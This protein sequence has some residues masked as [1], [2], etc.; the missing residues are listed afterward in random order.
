MNKALDKKIAIAVIVV[1]MI[2][3]QIHSVQFWYDQVG[4]TG[5]AFS[6]ALEVAML[7]LWYKE[8]RFLVRLAAA[9]IL[10][11]GP[12][13]VIT[14]PAVEELQKN[15]EIQEAVER[16]EAKVERLRE[17][18]NTYDENSEKFRGWAGRIDR[19]EAKLE[20]AEKELEDRYVAAKGLTLN[21]RLYMVAGMS[22]TVLLIVMITQLTAT[23]TFRTC[24]EIISGDDL[25]KSKKQL[26]KKPEISEKDR[27]VLAV[28]R[29]LKAKLP[30]YG[31]IASDMAKELGLSQKH[32]SQVFRYF[33]NKRDGKETISNNALQTMMVTLGVKKGE[34]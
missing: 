34:Y 10:I 6:I 25:K 26:E 11:A 28:A 1:S 19:T 33:E 16:A 18:K 20:R 4:W 7:W 13:Y 12:W 24:P 5:P 8:K 27:A 17:S 2:L 22:A 32:C 29:A 14:A 23:S 9:A 15:F 31:G 21:W 30:E 3:M